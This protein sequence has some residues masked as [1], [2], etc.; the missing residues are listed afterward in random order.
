MIELQK[1]LL[2]SILLL[3]IIYFSLNNS[4]VL[5]IVFLALTYLS[6]CEFNNLLIKIFKKK[7][8]L[9][10]FS[11]LACVIYLSIFSLTI[12]SFLIPLNNKSI[13]SLIFI[14][15]ICI[16]TD[17][18]GFIFGKLVGGKKLT[19]I[20]PNKTYSGVIGSF[21]L[22]MIS[23]Y[24]YYI[25]FKNYLI[26]E[27]NYLILIIIISLISQMGDLIISFLKR[28]AKIKDTGSILPGHGGILDR[29]DGVL[30]ALPFGLVL[31]SI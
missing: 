31:I 20:S 1:R 12:W 8:Q 7:D 30:I 3:V 14:I 23:G 15:L 21:F 17:I 25:F 27:I 16:T 2:T 22:S 24:F 9:Y 11:L 4:I 18:G 5:F 10:F 26:F 29:I 13:I 28:K 6:L 19:Q